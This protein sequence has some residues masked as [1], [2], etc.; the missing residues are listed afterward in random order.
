MI[1][2]FNFNFEVY[3]F[4]LLHEFNSSIKSKVD[5]LVHKQLCS[6]LKYILHTLECY[7][8]FLLSTN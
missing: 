2:K 4:S 3:L 5:N 6:I 8:Y 1:H 7:V